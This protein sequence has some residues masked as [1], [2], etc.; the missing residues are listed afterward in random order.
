MKKTEASDAIAQSRRTFIRRASTL[1]AALSKSLKDATQRA[2]ITAVRLRVQEYSQPYDQY[3]DLIDL[4]DGL[5]KL[6]NSKAVSAACTQVRAAIAKSV[7][8]SGAQGANVAR[9]H[10]TS[11]YFPKKQLCKLY[12]TLDFFKK[13]DWAVCI[14]DYAASLGSRGW[15]RTLRFPLERTPIPARA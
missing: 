10:G 5:E 14:K 7:I 3:V 15:N 9:Y 1:G 8:T 11:M 13:N 6:V 2:A 4:C 12:S